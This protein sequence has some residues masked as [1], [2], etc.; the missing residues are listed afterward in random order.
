MITVMVEMENF[1]KAQ[2]CLFNENNL[3]NS[4]ILSQMIIL[5]QCKFFLKQRIN[6]KIKMNNLP[7]PSRADLKFGISFT[8]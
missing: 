1:T 7:S 6:L 8:S 2:S 5:T 3:M 4:L